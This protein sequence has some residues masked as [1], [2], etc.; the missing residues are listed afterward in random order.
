VFPGSTISRFA[1]GFGLGVVSFILA[2]WS[3]ALG[4]APSAQPRPGAAPPGTHGLPGTAPSLRPEQIEKR[5]SPQEREKLG[6]P[7]PT[8]VA[9]HG[10]VHPD[11][12]AVL[13]T[14]QMPWLRFK[15]WWLAGFEGTAY[16]AVYLRH[17]EAGKPTSKENQA[18]IKEVQG[19]V[20]SRLTAA[21][22][23]L[24]HAFKNTAAIVGYV[25]S[26]GLAKLAQDA[27]VVAVALDDK[28][29][30]EDPSRPMHGEPGVAPGPGE[31]RGKVE[32][33]VYNALEK[34]P[35]GYVFVGVVVDLG[36]PREATLREKQAVAR[37]AQDRVLSA[38][39]AAELRLRSR[40]A[41]R[42]FFTAYVNRDGLAK[43]EEHPHVV[44]VGLNQLV[45]PLGDVDK[46]ER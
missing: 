45:R 21:E 19:R 11:V 39:S 41:F 38:V 37:N 32:V 10:K 29:V 16:V 31:R 22:F 42:G 14:G 15:G 24:V 17:E 46:N 27:D 7:E 18:A 13:E 1:V 4:Q 26:A 25:N 12:L 43:L 2:H 20:L 34:A 44:G 3:G 8:W 28:P 40:A 35:D 36:A 6:L 33:A 30:P 9:Q 23:S 5:I